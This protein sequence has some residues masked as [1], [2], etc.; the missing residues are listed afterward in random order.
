MFWAPSSFPGRMARGT[1]SEAEEADE[2]EGDQGFASQPSKLS[3]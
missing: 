2:E 1:R 3:S